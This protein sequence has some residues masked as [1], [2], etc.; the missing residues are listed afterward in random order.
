MIGSPT[1]SADNTRFYRLHYVLGG[2]VLCFVLWVRLKNHL[3]SDASFELSVP[4]QQA[5]A[6][7]IEESLVWPGPWPV[8]PQVLKA[9]V[10]CDYL[11]N[12]PEDVKLVIESI[13]SDKDKMDMQEDRDKECI[14]MK[15][16]VLW[17]TLVRIRPA[18]S[19]FLLSAICCLLSR[20]RC[21]LSAA[22][23][24]LSVVCCLL[25]T[26]C[27][28]VFAVCFLRSAVFFLSTRHPI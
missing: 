20:V 4:A 3:A 25:S 8:C 5:I 28:Q 6:T 2:V 27:Y 23:C 19:L 11:S 10:G 13:I 15:L 7:V 18:R 12:V 22:W 1:R 21:E 14:R 17:E 9:W 24:L 16:T 26:F